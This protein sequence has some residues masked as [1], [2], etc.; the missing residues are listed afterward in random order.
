MENISNEYWIDGELFAAWGYYF[1]DNNYLKENIQLFVDKYL[2]IAIKYGINLPSLVAENNTFDMSFLKR[3]YNKSNEVFIDLLLKKSYSDKFDKYI[4]TSFIFFKNDKNEIIGSI[5][6]ELEFFAKIADINGIFLES[7]YIG[8]RTNAFFSLLETRNS[9]GEEVF[10]DNSELA[11]L[12]T[13]RLNSYIRDL[14]ILIFEFCDNEFAFSDEYPI[15]DENGK[16]EL[17]DGIYLLIKGQ[18]LF[19]EDI[20]EFLPEEHKYKPFEEIQVELD[21]TNYKKYLESNR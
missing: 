3:K 17:Y 7:Y 18:V 16:S 13:T 4:T 20:Y 6:E 1:K 2:S 19:Y 12:N 11:Y 21:N 5:N 14:T 9:N 8:L 15:N 10:I